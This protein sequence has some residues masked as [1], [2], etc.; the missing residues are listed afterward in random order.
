MKYFRIHTAEIAY[1]TQ[2]PRG[3]FVAIW[4]LV[5]NKTLNEIE[6]KIYWD[7]RKWFEN[8]LPV[9]PFYELGNIEK[10]ITWYKDNEYGNSMMNKM[11]FYF[12]MANKY[13]LQLYKS[14]SDK[15]PG[16]VIY[17]DK[18]Q[19]A[20]INHDNEKVKTDKI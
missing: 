6:E 12:D 1:H 18:Y 3:L 7:N 8:N 10:A 2:Q 11:S 14:I 4:K 16:K 9:P 17:E 20:V 5:E 19:I 13:S 15:E